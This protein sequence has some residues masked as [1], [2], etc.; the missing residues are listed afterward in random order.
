MV[1]YASSPSTRMRDE[2]DPWAS[3]A[4][5]LGITNE[6][7]VPVKDAIWKTRWVPWKGDLAVKSTSCSLG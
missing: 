1:V 3:L 2:E 4:G 7:Q 6:P 5:Q